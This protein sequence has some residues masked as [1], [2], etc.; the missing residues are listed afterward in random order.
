MISVGGMRNFFNRFGNGCALAL[1]GAFALSLVI[2]YGNNGLGNRVPHEGSSTA[3]T[4]IATV[5]GQP[6]TEAD[7]REMSARLQSQGSPAPGKAFA[8]RQGE[9][10]QQLIQKAIITQEAKRRNVHPLEADIDKQV[11][12]FRTMIAQNLSKT[13]LSDQEFSDYLM[14]NRGM[15]VSDLR[16]LAAKDLI[17]LAL[18]NSVKAD[19]KVTEVEARNQTAQVHLIVVNVPYQ[20]AATPPLPTQKKKPLTEAEARQKAEALYARVKGGADISLVEKSNTDDPGGAKNGGDVAMMAEYPS[21]TP[22]QMSISLNMLYGNDFADAVHK[23]TAGQTSE[24]MK[25][26]GFQK[27]YGFFKL[28]DR[29]INTPKDFDPKKAVAALTQQRAIE[30]LTKLIKSETKSAK[31]DIKDLDKKAYYDYAKLASAQQESIQ[32]MMSGIQSVPPSPQESDAQQAVI[33]K[34]FDAMLKRHPNDT[35]A[36]IMVADNIK[37]HRMME[38]GAQD[39]LLA[40]DETIA[41]NTD[42]FDRHFELADMYREKKQYDKAKLHLD[43]V[44]KTYRLQHSLRPGRVPI[45][46]CDPSKIG[47]SLPQHQ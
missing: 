2:G 14:N 43:R 29:K 37:Q 47:N 30:K 24:V 32:D 6:I 4:V 15:T 46:R 17:P 38:P 1:L 41:K 11:D 25:L 8:T 23:M 27:G 9:I 33:N 10:M 44:A 12:S 13:K 45:C 19:E 34:E 36:A 3:D 26:S 40:I 5:N 35:T 31:I 7:F 20:D 22:G 21:S 42:D 28:L 18:V 39:R 16:Q